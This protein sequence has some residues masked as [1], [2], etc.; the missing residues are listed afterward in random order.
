MNEQ[1]N[2]SKALADLERTIRVSDQSCTAYAILRDRYKKYSTSLDLFILFLST[3]LTAMVWAQP[4]I[5][6]QL[7]PPNISKDIWLGVLSVGAFCLSLL[8]LLVNWKARSNSFQQALNVLST[9]VKELRP[10]RAVPELEKIE[11]A[12]QRYQAITEPLEPIPEVDFLK[13][14]K[15]HRLKLK[16]SRHLDE[17]PGTNIW[18]LKWKFRLLDNY[19]TLRNKDQKDTL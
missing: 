19:A 2:T 9:Y 7:T 4:T 16:I 10:L 17:Y 6:E 5:A 15:H 13:L 3:W 14:K 8:Q 11:I 1:E 18:L 12:L